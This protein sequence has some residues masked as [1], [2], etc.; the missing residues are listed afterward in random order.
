MAGIGRLVG[1]DV[2]Q[3]TPIELPTYTVTDSRA[4]PPPEKWWYA[5]IVG[6]EVLSNASERST[7]ELVGDFQRFSQALNLVWP[8]V[9]RTTAVPTSL[10]IC[11]RGGQFDKFRPQKEDKTDADQTTVGVTLRKGEMSAIVIDYETKSLNV[12]TPETLDALS[13]VNADGTGIGGGNPGFRVDAYRQLYRQYVHFLLRGA[14]PRGPAWFEEGLA[15]IFMAME[16]TS[17]SITVGKV[18]DPNTI[19]AEQAAINDSGATGTAAAED[20]DFN[21]ALARRHLIPMEEFF[22]VTH[23]SPAAAGIVAGVWAKEAYAFV[24]WGLYGEKGKHQKAFIT[25]LKRLDREPVSEALFKECFKQTYREM[26]FT[27]RGYVDFTDHNYAGVEAEKGQ[28]LP[29]SPPFELREATEPEVGR[30]KGDALVLAGNLTEARMAMTTPLIRGERDVPLLGAVGLLER[31]SGDDAKARKIL[32]AAAQG[33]VSRPRVYLE[34]ARMRFAE[35]AANPAAPDGRFSAEQTASVLTPLFTA[36]NQK[37]ALVEV[38]ELI[39]QAWARSVVTPGA[40]HLIVLEEGVVLFP[41]NSGLVYA[42]AGQEIRA[43]LLSNATKLIDYGL[44]TAPDAAAKEKFEKLKASLP[45]K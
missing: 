16:I 4:L 23:D 32:E 30:I 45:A 6:F 5:R 42:T 44:R 17:K 8:G 19:S 24:H 14:E 34:L 22:A 2:S 31:A 27:L 40:D 26:E 3:N 41:K 1:Q 25:F 39:A 9:Q 29:L 36:R 15:Q 20:R 13:L 7:K 33:K 37:P 28:K 18:E 12:V 11:G 43:G 21:A 35:A 38:Y 10:I